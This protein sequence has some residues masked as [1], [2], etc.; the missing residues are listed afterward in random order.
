MNLAA[1]IRKKFANLLTEHALPID[2]EN[3]EFPSWAIK[4]KNSYAVAIEVDEKI[5]INESF[6]NVSY[7]TDYFTIEGDRKHLLILSSSENKLRNEFA[8]VCAIFLE[9]GEGNIKRKNI[10]DNPIEW[11]KKWKDLIGNKSIDSTVHGVLGE[12]I[13]LYWVRKYIDNNISCNNWT[14]PNG[15]SI[16]IETPNKQIEVKSTLIKYNNIVTISGQ[17]QLSDKYDMSLVLVKLEEVNT[18]I[19]NVISI[20][21]MLEKLEKLGLNKEELNQKVVRMGFQENSL[22]RKKTFRILEII[23]YPITEKFPIISPSTLKDNIDKDRILQITYKIELSGLE[24]REIK[25]D[26]EE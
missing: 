11:W 5:K 25:L 13:I 18:H 1:Q 6:S 24:N 3:T 15:K 10:I 7:Y 22:A 4:F 8:G 23:E 26:I 21:I 12:L 14:G 19:K 9:K 17:Y 20:D 16:D 2:D